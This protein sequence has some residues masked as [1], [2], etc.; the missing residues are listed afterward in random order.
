M[1]AANTIM[2]ARVRVKDA[3]EI[4]RRNA[5]EREWEERE[6]QAALAAAKAPGGER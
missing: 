3:D 6:Y 4:E 5:I 2:K 1:A